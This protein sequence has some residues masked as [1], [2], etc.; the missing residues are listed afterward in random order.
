MTDLKI[1]HIMNFS[2]QDGD[3]TIFGSPVL[4]FGI[5]SFNKLLFFGGSY[6][7]CLE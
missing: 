4:L 2:L 7:M 3:I 1:Y 6:M 5:F